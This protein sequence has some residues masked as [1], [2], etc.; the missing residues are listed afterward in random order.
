MEE[1]R[2][3][4][5]ATTY[6]FNYRKDMVDMDLISTHHPDFIVSSPPKAMII[7]W[8]YPFRSPYVAIMQ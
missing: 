2:V 7:R 3:V 5:K 4:E 6:P 8:S 1:G